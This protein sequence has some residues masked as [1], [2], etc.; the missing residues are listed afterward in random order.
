MN[1]I[2]T[3]SNDKLE[4]R[5]LVPHAS[6][7]CSQASSEYGSPGVESAIFFPCVYKLKLRIHKATCRGWQYRKQMYNLV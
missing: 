6:H 2:K 3:H 5:K 4:D 1:R 7:H